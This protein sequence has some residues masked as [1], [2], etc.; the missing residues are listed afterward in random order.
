[1]TPDDL[2]AIIRASAGEPEGGALDGEN[3]DVAF[4]DLGYDS[5]QLLEIA[6]H[7]E[8]KIDIA[9]SDNI[10]AETRTIRELLLVIDAAV[11]GRPAR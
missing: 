5:I 2:I 11:A 4:D 7:I 10:V 3:M 1:M 6:A 9:L 8:R